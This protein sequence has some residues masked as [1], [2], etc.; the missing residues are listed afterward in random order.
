[1]VSSLPQWQEKDAP[2]LQVKIAV[3]LAKDAIQPV[4]PAEI[5]M[6]FY[7]HYFIIPKKGDELRSVL[8]LQV[9]NPLSAW[10]YWHT[11]GPWFCTNMHFPQ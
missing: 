11:A 1:M 2:G 4:P 10:T 9:L 3:L 5:E 6:G 8:D 7:S